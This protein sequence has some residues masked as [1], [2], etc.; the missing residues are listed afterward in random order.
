MPNA[1]HAQRPYM[2]LGGGGGGPNSGF[3]QR[4]YWRRGGGDGE[5]NSG[6]A[7]RPY[8]RHGSEGRGSISGIAQ[9]PYMRRGGGGGEPNSG[10]AQRPYRR[11]S[12]GGGGQTRELR[13]DPKGGAA[14]WVQATGAPLDVRAGAPAGQL[15]DETAGSAPGPPGLGEALAHEVMARRLRAKV[16]L[17]SNDPIGGPVTVAGAGDQAR[18]ASA[19][20]GLG[21]ARSMAL[22]SARLGA[23]R[24]RDPG[25]RFG[26][27]VLL[28][29]EP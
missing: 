13:N 24:G 28:V 12:G 19:V 1:G 27:A 7:Q 6:H 29:G 22:G 21:L 25:A 17:R 20:A 10:Y 11:H 23:E 26:S 9:R 3:V 15:A 14:A 18:V 8:T 2:R 16:G 4:P 5:P